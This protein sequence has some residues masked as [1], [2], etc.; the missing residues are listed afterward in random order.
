MA[1]I[2]CDPNGRKRILFIGPDGQRRP[3]RLGKVT[4]RQAEAGKLRVEQLVS[5]SILGHPPDDETNR[6]L[7]GLDDVMHA[8]L[9]AVGLTRP[10][11]SLL[12]K[13]WLDKYAADRQDWKPASI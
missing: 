11:Q 7:A 12:L 8:R 6:W 5:S 9:A 13:D 2:A 1:S 4:A 10:R 3:L